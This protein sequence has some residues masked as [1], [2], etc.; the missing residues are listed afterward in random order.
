M[1]DDAPAPEAT[2]PA[3]PTEPAK[4]AAEKTVSYDRFTEVN[5]GYK[6]L[7]AELAETQRKLQEREEA[8]MSAADRE[9][10]GRARAEEERDSVKAETETYKRSR[11]IA[12]AARGTGF[13]DPDFAAEYLASRGDIETDAQA[14]KAVEALAKRI[15]GLVKQEPPTPQLGQVLENGQPVDPKTATDAHAKK[16]FENDLREAVGFPTG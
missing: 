14:T 4:P 1:S 11:L 3:A 2:Q 10:A 8:E 6:S 13:T 5:E 7:K 15:P 16:R 9:K 12:K